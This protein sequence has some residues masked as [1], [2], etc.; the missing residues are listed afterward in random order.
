MKKK[1]I[2]DNSELKNEHIVKV[3]TEKT[4]NNQNEY[5]NN[6]RIRIENEISSNEEFNI[7]SKGN[8][9]HINIE[10]NENNNINI[11]KCIQC[12]KKIKLIKNKDEF[13]LFL[14]EEIFKCKIDEKCIENLQKLYNNIKINNLCEDCIIKEIFIGGVNNLIYKINNNNDKIINSISQFFINSFIKRLDE[15]NE[16]MIKN[17]IETE[18]IMNKIT[19]YLMIYNKNQFQLFNTN[20]NECKDHLKNNRDAYL[21]LYN[22]IIEENEILKKTINIINNPVNI[23]N[24][25]IEKFVNQMKEIINE[26]ISNSNDNKSQ[27]NKTFLLSNPFNHINDLL[28]NDIKTPFQKSLYSISPSNNNNPLNLKNKIN[29]L[30][31]FD[32]PKDLNTINNNNNT[33]SLSNN[34]FPSLNPNILLDYSSLNFNSNNF[35]TSMNDSLNNNQILNDFKI[36]SNF[37]DN[38]NSQMFNLPLNQ[39]NQYFGMKNLYIPSHMIEQNKQIQNNFNPK[40]FGNINNESNNLLYSFKDVI[41]NSNDLI[42]NFYDG[43]KQKNKNKNIFEGKT[44]NLKNMFNELAR[45]KDIKKMNNNNNGQNIQQKNKNQDIQNEN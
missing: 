20:M 32:L 6:K 3:N 40:L 41:N 24:E 10:N 33:N 21:K 22:S 27:N 13:F 35:F 18:E 29:P 31:T 15:I 8:I 37:S 17:E 7:E 28:I 34:L 26:N 1:D 25:K 12:E 2:Q 45:Q 36:N 14:K 16:S 39:F 11:I 19:C 5:L 44:G 9:L 43:N 38:N 42:H 4:E 23:T 30:N